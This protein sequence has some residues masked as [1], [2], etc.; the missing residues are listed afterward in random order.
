[1]LVVF[2]THGPSTPSAVE[3]VF[4]AV[5]LAQEH[6][7]APVLILIQ[8]GVLHAM[9]ADGGAVSSLIEAGVTVLADRFSLA[10]RGIDPG[11]LPASI[12]CA[13]MPAFVELLTHDGV[14]P[15]W[16]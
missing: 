13:E 1:M 15:L 14:R 5:R 8:E 12:T 9:H 11:R 7:Q 2:E 10:L 6:G 16:H 4:S 3:E